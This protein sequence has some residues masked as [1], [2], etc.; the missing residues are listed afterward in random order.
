MESSLLWDTTS[1]S[2]LKDNR[3]FGGTCRFSLP[4][5]YLPHADFLL[6]L[7][8][9]PEDEG[10]IFL[11][12]VCWVPSDYGVVSSSVNWPKCVGSFP[13]L[14]LMTEAVPTSE[15]SYY[16]TVNETVGNIQHDVLYWR[17]EHCHS[18]RESIDATSVQS[19]LR[20]LADEKF[21]RSVWRTY[22]V[23]YE[24]FFFLPWW[25]RRLQ[26]EG[27]RL[28][29]AATQRSD[30]LEHIWVFIRSCDILS[31]QPATISKE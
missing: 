21:G 8:F 28:G 16:L 7:I 22:T 31:W 17:T 12:S 24:L 30:L 4:T 26:K 18:L 14:Y 10:N 6:G 1:C 19:D 9:D 23:H 15:T 27:G 25:Q 2:L 13:F 29:R 20:I 3:R 11:R 5:C